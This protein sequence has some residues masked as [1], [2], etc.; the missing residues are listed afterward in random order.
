MKVKT[1]L[2]VSSL[3]LLAG[4]TV[5]AEEIA[6]PDYYIELTE[7]IGSQYNICPEVLQAM[8]WV[9]SRFVEDAEN[10][11]CKG[12]M[13]VSVNVHKELISSLGYT[14]IYEPYHNITVAC[15]ILT[16]YMGSDTELYNA[17]YKYNGGSTW[18]AE[19]VLEISEKLEREHGK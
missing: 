10:G 4:G 5:H 7:E 2:L 9:E 11:S 12:L 14:N 18:Y 8:A 19:K 6:V 15:E 1:I 3:V 16:E 17:L 13:Q